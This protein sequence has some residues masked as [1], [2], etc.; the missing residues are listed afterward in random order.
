MIGV[1]L[2][3]LLLV[4]LILS[5]FISFKKGAEYAERNIYGT[6]WF[7]LIWVGWAI[8]STI[9]VIRRKLWKRM[10]LFFIHLS[11]LLIFFGAL[12][13][14]G[15]GSRGYLLLVRGKPSNSY[16]EYGSGSIKM[17][18]FVLELKKFE[19]LYY[20]DTETP[21]DYVSHLLVSEG[22]SLPM[23]QR[24][25]MNRIFRYKGYRI[26][27]SSYDIEEEVNWLT[28]NFDPIGTVIT[29]SGYILFLISML[30]WL[31][32]PSGEFMRILK[33]PLL[34]KGL[35]IIVLFLIT[36]CS[37]SNH[38]SNST[39]GE[40][41]YYQT[42]QTCQ[43]VD[44]GEVIR[45]VF[46]LNESVGSNQMIEKLP[47]VKAKIEKVYSRVG[48]S[49]LHFVFNILAGVLGLVL[50]LFAPIKKANYLKLLSRGYTLLISLSFLF[51]TLCYA[52]RWYI[53][54]RV[55]LSG[56]YE[57]MMF[58][59]LFSMF[60]AIIFRKRSCFII[61]FGFLSSGFC[62]L[63]AFLGDMNTNIT[64]LL[65]VLAS[66]WLS[67]HVSFIMMSYSLFTLTTFNGIIALFI[68]AERERLMLLSRF[69][70]YPALYLLGAGIIFGSI[71]ANLSWG[72]YWSWDPKEVW[73]LI[74]FMVYG[75][76]AHIASLV[77]T[78]IALKF[79]LFML[80]AYITLLMTYFGVN[81]FLGGM[82][83]YTG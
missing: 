14:R 62:M 39:A 7:C 40:R 20:S 66:P 68:K 65:P 75:G 18:P 27:Q 36:S 29:Y 74:A 58:M 73:A 10:A 81:F 26:Y 55:P 47:E 4:V 63:V 31:L 25:S 57:T 69:V 28:V 56:G 78:N 38:N 34:R 79:N 9:L 11:F 44:S 82:H 80:L 1:M 43:E 77:K 64:P 54:G 42:E 41:L 8:I 6:I 59:A 70:L 16:I 12:L 76:A 45:A 5:T 50:I 23:S 32:S 71:W 37:I 19:T 2:N 49:R 3:S 67:I 46:G 83:S 22:E 53:A 60:T 51:L 21:S 17:L 48:K 33:N 15:F 35:S 61:P 13:T 30:C 24:V 52:V 72:N